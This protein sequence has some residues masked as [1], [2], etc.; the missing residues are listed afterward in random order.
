MGNIVL[1]FVCL[2][3]GMALRKSGR[4][5]ADAHVALNMFIIHV[6]LP[7]VTLLQVHKIVLQPA[8]AYSIAMPWL[9]FAAVT[10]R[11][12]GRP[13]HRAR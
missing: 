11:G 12:A 8:L 6:S 2:A 9:L 1:L 4:A 13:S 7:A 3:I 10:R 5:P